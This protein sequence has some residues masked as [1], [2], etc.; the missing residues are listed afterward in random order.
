MHISDIDTSAMLF[1]PKA[2]GFLSTI[3]KTVPNIA[4]RR[5]R[6]MRDSDVLKYI[7]LM[8]DIN[9]PIIKEIDDWWKRK[10]EAAEAAGFKI[11]IEEDDKGNK[12]SK[13]EK[14]TERMLIGNSSGVIDAII[15]FLAYLK[16]P[17]WT[18]LVY[19]NEELLNHT[20]EALSGNKGSAKDIKTVMMLHD[21]I[22]DVVTKFI[23]VNPKEETQKFIDRMYHRIE[24]SRLA[25]KP[26]DYAKRI[27][28]G[29]DLRE[30]SP[31][32]RD[33]AVN[34]IKFV[35]DAIPED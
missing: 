13:F 9:S 5:Y 24:Q 28:A 35:G 26:E 34:R 1:D 23:G 33:Y 25:I 4:T 29:E 6:S 3:K 20:V 18:E 10:F 22:G 11:I 16:K 21:S 8:Y 19:L 17:R 15:D 27:Q 32:G 2:K 12:I 7:V 14:E 30:D 31:Y